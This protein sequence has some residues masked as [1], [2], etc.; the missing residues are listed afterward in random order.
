V[1]PLFEGGKNCKNREIPASP[2]AGASRPKQQKSREDE[3][4][5]DRNVE[6][7]SEGRKEKQTQKRIEIMDRVGVQRAQEALDIAH[8]MANLLGTGLDHQTLSILITLCK[9]G[10]NPEAL[11]AMVKELHHKAAALSATPSPVR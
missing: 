7:E 5:V 10:V 11:A 1:K 4:S 2:V 8:V 6:E 3:T 9:H